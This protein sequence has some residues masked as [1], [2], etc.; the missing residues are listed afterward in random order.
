MLAVGIV[1]DRDD[2][3]FDLLQALAVIPH[4]LELSPLIVIDLAGRLIFLRRRRST[5][6]DGHRMREA[7]I[8]R[9]ERIDLTL[10]DDQLVAALF[11]RRVINHIAIPERALA[12]LHLPKLFTGS[13]I[14]FVHDIAPLDEREHHD[15]A[16]R[17]RNYA[18]VDAGFSGIDFQSG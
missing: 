16:L 4:E 3:A 5:V 14:F 12:A 9:G 2:E 7:A 1:V 6:W 10:G 11:E 17:V 8:D 18:A 15:V 13:A